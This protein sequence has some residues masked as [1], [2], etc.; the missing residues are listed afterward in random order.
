M[1][2]R[3]FLGNGS[4]LLIGTA[5]LISPFG[6]GGTV[7]QN[8]LRV[9]IIGAGIR[10]MQ[11]MKVIAE[12]V[13]GL[14]V[15]AVCDIQEDRLRNGLKIAEYN[16]NAHPNYKKL[17]EDKKVEAVIIATPL[18]LHFQMTLDALAAG[19]HVYCEKMMAHTIDQTLKMRQVVLTSDRVLQVGYQERE[20]P[21]FQQVD[22]LIRNGACGNLTYIDC[23]WNR[24]GNWR[25]PVID[26]RLEKLINWRMYKEYSGGLMAELC[27]HQIDL[28]NWLSQS[29]P[30]KVSGMGGIDFW[31]DGR[32][33]FD[34]VTALF[35]YEN[36]FKAKFT[37]LTTNAKEG[38]RMKFYGTK[39][40]IEINRDKGQQGFI[41]QEQHPDERLLSVDAVT[42]AS[43]PLSYGDK[44]IPIVSS[45]SADL[46]YSTINAI[47]Q[48]SQSV[49][50]K[51][52]PASNA[53][54]AAIASL[55]VHMAN[56]AM[57]TDKTI[58]WKQDYD[59][60]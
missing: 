12:S 58:Y 2:R 13:P 32:E 36:G 34:N 42:G 23:F 47:R 24:N 18:S 37:A 8:P 29:H 5:T 54:T 9:G 48:F 49:R 10:G 14:S 16:A 27:S 56:E 44:G 39:A 40:T 28:V 3:K 26:S 51:S 35:Q 45:H 57:D 52:T 53:K 6:S 38:F 60:K 41:Y 19:K 22:R 55:A 33:T 7:T 46:N 17:L 11:L 30:T 50:D 43:E 21:L 15:V 31:K 1:D 59:L 20:S 25:Q 4:K